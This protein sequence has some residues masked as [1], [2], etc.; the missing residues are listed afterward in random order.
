MES[1]NPEIQNIGILI[2]GGSGVL[3]SKIFREVLSAIVE[4]HL[5]YK[6]I[7]FLLPPSPD[8]KF[9]S[10][11]DISQYHDTRVR[12]QQEAQ[13]L[14][15]TYETW[16]KLGVKAVFRTSVNAEALYLFRS[17]LKG[18]KE[19]GIDTDKGSR[20]QVVRDMAEGFYANSHY[21]IEPSQVTFEGAYS[22]ERLHA[23]LKYVIDLGEKKAD[24]A[25]FSNADNFKI[26]L[27]YK[28]HL[29]SG[30][31]DKWLEEFFE[32][33]QEKAPWRERITLF[34][35][36]TGFTELFKFARDRKGEYLLVA[37]SN[38]VGDLLYEPLIESIEGI[39]DKL[40]LYSISRFFPPNYELCEFQ[41]VHGSADDKTG[42][43]LD[44]SKILPYATLRIA[45]AI[46]ELYFN[47][48]DC[49]RK[50]DEITAKTIL[51]FYDRKLP[52]EEPFTAEIMKKVT[53]LLFKYELINKINL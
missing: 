51:F 28:F 43:G 49:R 29:F 41:T 35:P 9:S 38:E 5:G 1:Y 46:A 19:F 18:F 6:A 24:N 37:C 10:Y 14:V 34:Q 42:I 2:G 22:R 8:Y 45:A 48:F 16:H 53:E 23:I 13:K 26:W 50:M 39:A 32:L 40:I 30:I 25:R 12:S 15:E 27:V 44:S 52:D 47:V 7:N 11:K 21:Q 31:F 20:I 36:D 17:E 3:L 4:K 33:N